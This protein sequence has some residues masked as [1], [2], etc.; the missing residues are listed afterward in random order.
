MQEVNKIKSNK[1]KWNL[2]TT[3]LIAV[4]GSIMPL[5]RNL[6]SVNGGITAVESHNYFLVGAAVIS[7]FLAY[8]VVNH[9]SIPKRNTQSFYLS[10]LGVHFIIHIVIGLV[11]VMVLT[12]FIQ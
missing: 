8:Q 6:F 10:I 5:I 2:L 12:M 1:P 3:F 4:I 11:S 7:F 9:M